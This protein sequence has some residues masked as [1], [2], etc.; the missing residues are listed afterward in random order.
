MGYI[1]GTEHLVVCMM[2]T[3]RYHFRGR[4]NPLNLQRHLHQ[5]LEREE[6]KLIL[7]DLTRNLLVRTAKYVERRTWI[8]D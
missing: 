6:R 3:G 8:P 5:F 1:T 4:A 2:T 7:H